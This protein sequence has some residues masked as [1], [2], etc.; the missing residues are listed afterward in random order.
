MKIL[1]G[2]TFLSHFGGGERL[3]VELV[4]YASSKG[5]EVV[6]AGTSSYE[7]P[8]KSYLLPWTRSSIPPRELTEQ[9][10]NTLSGKAY[11]EFAKIAEK[12]RPDAIFVHNEAQLLRFLDKPQ[13]P[14]FWCQEPPRLVFENGALELIGRAHTRVYSTLLRGLIKPYWTDHLKKIPKVV[15]SNSRY[16]A[17]LLKTWF[18]VSSIVRYN[19]V[20][21]SRFKRVST[22]KGSIIFYPSRINPIKRQLLALQALSLMKDVDWKMIF[23]GKIAD[24]KYYETLLGF[25]EKNDMRDRVIFMDEMKTQMAEAYSKAAITLYTPY[26]EP[27]G[28]VPVESMACGT[29]VVCVNEGGVMETV[30]NNKTGFLCDSTPEAIAEKLRILLTDQKLGKKMGVAGRAHVVRNFGMKK[31]CTGILDDLEELV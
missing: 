19:W 5:H 30:V 11:R 22:K 27:F 8:G 13:N 14:Y 31:R 15:A 16:T 12:E 23:V 6:F 3:L 28:L 1:F 2:S 29:P 4:K 20:D 10:Y 9:F 18:N 21:T 25:C 17:S 26:R 24:V 7:G